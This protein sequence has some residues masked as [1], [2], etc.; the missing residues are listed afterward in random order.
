MIRLAKTCVNSRNRRYHWASWPGPERIRGRCCPRS[1]VEAFSITS[2]LVRCVA[3]A[4]FLFPPTGCSD[5]DDVTKSAAPSEKGPFAP[6]P[7]IQLPPVGRP[8]IVVPPIA[9][10]P[11]FRQPELCD[12]GN[13]CTVDTC[14]PLLGCK[15]TLRTPGEACDDGNFCTTGDACT[16]QGLC[17]GEAVSCEDHNACTADSCVQATGA[18]VHEVLPGQACDDGNVCTADDLCDGTGLC[19]GTEVPVDDDNACTADTCDAQSGVR[20]EPVQAGTACVGDGVGEWIC[21]GQG[22]CSSLP[23][24]ESV[25]GRVGGYDPNVRER[26]LGAGRHPVSAFD[27]LV[28]VAFIESLHSGGARVGVVSLSAGGTG[29]GLWRSG[30][31]VLESAP[32]IASV[33]GGFVVAYTD[34]G[35]DGD[36]LG[37]AVQRLASD[38]SALGPSIVANQTT[39]FGQHS[40]DL[41]W[42]G[43]SFVVAWEDD[44]MGNSWDRR[45]CHRRFSVDA[46]ALGPEQCTGEQA[47]HLSTPVLASTT[48]GVARAWRKET[49]EACSYEVSWNG[50][51]WSIQVDGY[52]DS[53]EAPSMAQLDPDHLLMV[54]TDGWDRQMATVIHATEGPSVVF[55]LEGGLYARRSPSLAVTDDGVYLAW[56]ERALAPSV[57]GD[58]VLV[59]RGEW[60][61]AQMTWAVDVSVVPYPDEWC[62]GDQNRGSLA[63]V[64][65]APSGALAAVWNDRVNRPGGPEHGD[66][67]LSILRTPI[68]GP[69]AK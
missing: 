20:H 53:G 29:L 37:V 19:V 22:V 52:P 46:V 43:S 17:E 35:T 15:H 21:D 7:S 13:D 40:P 69:V 9:F 58:D 49:F 36:G 54:Y 63:G 23:E 12:D 39:A 62:M 31:T 45:V 27:A 38:A 59:R 47:A 32:V 50:L 26:T 41:V 61:G 67:L 18:C 10:A 51:G 16:L 57:Y 34:V 8:P 11:C 64:V 5:A 55:V 33:P 60:D 48:K 3:T 1:F 66:V 6:I 68:V 25:I 28:G 56:W 14:H 65:M 42:D 4:A 2:R 44:S 24:T 30:L